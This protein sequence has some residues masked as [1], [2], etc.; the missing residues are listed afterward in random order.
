M[1]A[2]TLIYGI[3]SA[4]TI[5]IMFSLIL[6]IM[7]RFS[8]Q[9]TGTHW[10][11]EY[12]L[13]T[14]YYFYFIAPFLRAFVMKK[15]HSEEFK[16]LW[17]VNRINRLPLVFTILVRIIIALIFIFYICNYLSHFTNALII[18]IAIGLLTLMILSRSMKHRSIQLERLFVQNLRSREIAAQVRGSRR[19]LFEDI[20]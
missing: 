7:R 18:V 19:P 2:N 1:V 3:L 12:D 11:G 15:N 17:T 4:A 13:W 9:L 5:I 8:V 16:T 6:P 10:A 20:Y 14:A